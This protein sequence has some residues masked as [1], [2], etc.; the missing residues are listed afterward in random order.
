MKK[1]VKVLV[2]VLCLNMF[3]PSI[4]PNIGVET[5]GAAT[6]IKLNYTKKTIYVGDTFTLKVTETKSKIKWSSSNKKVATVNSKGKVKGIGKGTAKITATVGGK[7]YTCKV[8]VKSI[9]SKSIKLDKT[10][11]ECV[12]GETSKINATV[13]PSN[14][15]DKTLQWTSYDESIAI[16]NSK[17]VVTGIASGETTITVTNGNS[18]ASCHVIV[19]DSF[20]Y[21]YLNAENGTLV[22]ATSNKSS[23]VYAIEFIVKYY[24]GEGKLVYKQQNAG[25]FY[26]VTK[27]RVCSFFAN[28]PSC[29]YT[30]YTIEAK[31]FSTV[32]YKSDLYDKISVSNIYFV[33][34]EGEYFLKYTAENPTEEVISNSKIIFLC[35][36][37]GSVKNI[38]EGY[39]TL[40]VNEKSEHKVKINEFYDS[41]TPVVSTAW[42]T[43]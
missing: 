6:K 43:Y 19:K 41:I 3:A 9:D 12:V 24:N 8:T 37:N 38:V 23:E 36:R 27:N 20:S 10:E 26:H 4:S 32:N 18:T 22:Y 13:V 25:R 2:L 16:V 42:V 5:V 15:T 33:E 28:K 7:K 39:C 31:E 40:N 17:G 21:E 34:E 14:T 11:I 30:S 1:F 35:Y 29:A